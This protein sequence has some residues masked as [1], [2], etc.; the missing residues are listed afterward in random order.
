[1]RVCAALEKAAGGRASTP[2]WLPRPPVQTRPAFPPESTFTG[3]FAHGN[4]KPFLLPPSPQVIAEALSGSVR[5][6][7]M[8]KAVVEVYV[9]V[10]QAH[11]GEL[12]AWRGVVWGEAK[13]YRWVPLTW[14]E[15]V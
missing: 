7:A 11:G 12:G 5:L 6:E 8:P 4:G 3:G 14:D 9:L 13:W 1:M 10:L 2:V 15:R